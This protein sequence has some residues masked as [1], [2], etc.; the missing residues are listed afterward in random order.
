M[1]KKSKRR[2]ERKRREGEKIIRDNFELKGGVYSLKSP[3][4]PWYSQIWEKIENFF[5][6]LAWLSKNPDL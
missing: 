5:L 1:D 3:P 2:E 6:T 4:K